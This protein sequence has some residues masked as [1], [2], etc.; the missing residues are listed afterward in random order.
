MPRNALPRTNELPHL[1][2]EALSLRLGS[3]AILRD[4]SLALPAGSY[5]CLLG[6]SGSGKSTLLGAIAGLLRPSAGRI[7]IGGEDVYAADPARNVP[8]QRRR[9]GMVFQDPT[10]WPHMS[11]LANVL[12]ALRGGLRRERMA[13]GLALLE[14]LGLGGLAERRPHQLSGGQRQRVAIARAIIA[15]PTLVL[16]DEP[17]SAV[18]QALRDDLRGFLRAL[19]AERGGTALHVTHDPA[20]AFE[21]GD[22]LGVLERG[23]LLQWDRP[24]RIYRQPA[25]AGVA[26]LTGPASLVP[27][28]VTAVA[29]GTAQAVLAGWT[30]TSSAHPAVS[31]G[32]ALLCLRPEAVRLGVAEGWSAELE[33]VRYQGDAY[34][35][36]LRLSDG[37]C[38]EATSPEPPRATVTL[39]LNEDRAWLLPPEVPPATA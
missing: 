1:A 6:Q 16:L 35:A 26:R 36:V 2:V 25:S 30:L 19:F 8:P 5:G 39:S 20:E 33:K 18:D 28:T 17:L 11:V 31:P 13:I 24:E 21:L 27:V 12:Y 37:A 7:V 9:I 14:R 10:L 4:V 22:M 34:A 32:P 23:R 29:G 38:I 3:A 15:A